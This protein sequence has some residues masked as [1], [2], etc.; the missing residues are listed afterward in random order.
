MFGDF[1]LRTIS[2]ILLLT[3]A[4]FASGHGGGTDDNGGHTDNR[5][6]IYHQHIDGS[7]KP[8]TPSRPS[9]GKSSGT[10]ERSSLSAKVVGIQD[11]DTITVLHGEEQYKIRIWGID[12][13]EMGQPFGKA[14][15][16]A[17][18]QLL[19]EKEV[20]FKLGEKD[21]YGRII[22]TV[23]MPNGDDFGATMLLSGH[24]WHYVQYAPHAEGYAELQAK[25][26]RKKSGLWA[27]QGAVAPWDW[28]KKK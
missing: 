15:K 12:T 2:G 26:K 13:P 27:E 24:A 19:F 20:Q 8:S 5:T 22:S 6:G 4:A 10:V 18:S 3:L 23:T 14:A 7:A 16:Q 11:G 28:R 17:A 1:E 25:A 21:R 9:T